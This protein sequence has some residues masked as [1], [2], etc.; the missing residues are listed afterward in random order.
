[1]LELDRLTLSLVTLSLF[2]D[3]IVLENLHLAGLQLN[4][5][6]DANGQGNWQ[7]PGDPETPMEPKGEGKRIVIKDIRVSGS[8]IRYHNG[9]KNLNH[10]LQVD[11]FS[12]NQNPD[13]IL[14]S[15][16]DG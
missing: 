14:H 4:I 12:Q 9:G 3:I 13:G 2:K 16:F 10:L 8:E 15:S 7:V 1:M 5:A 6:T 11:T